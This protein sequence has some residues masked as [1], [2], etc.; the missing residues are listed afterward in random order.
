MKISIII[1][2]FNE[3]KRLKKVLQAISRQTF[4][5]FE[6]IIVDSES[7]DKTLEIAKSFD[8]RIIHIKKNDF[9]YSY[10]SNVGCENAQ[11]DILVFLSGHSCPVRKNYLENVVKIFSQN[12]V[13][14]A[15]GDT[16]PYWNA[17]FVE[18]LFYW[19]GH[20]KNLLFFNKN[21]VETKVRPGTLSCSNAAFLKKIWEKHHFSLDF[22][23]GGEDLYFAYQILNEGYKIIKSNKMLVR[24]SH[25][26]N[27]KQF[28]KE[29]K[30][31]SEMYK[32]FESTINNE[33]NKQ[34]I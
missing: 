1:R 13:G 24:H 21:I 8:C 14:G 34:E 19:L 11:G 16:I 28:R 7:T 2:T 15:Y 9:N 10:S 17:G 32:N 25:G 26:K 3:E 12:D 29:M 31:W 18:F 6:I 4:R 30:N 20:I 33:T 22:A 5:D 23:K 27:F